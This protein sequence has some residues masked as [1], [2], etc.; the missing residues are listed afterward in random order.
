ML[1]VVGICIMEVN[2]ESPHWDKH[3]GGCQGDAQTHS[4][5]ICASI[6]MRPTRQ[7]DIPFCCVSLPADVD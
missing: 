3:Y 1:I 2:S 4:L 7:W 5:H 6:I